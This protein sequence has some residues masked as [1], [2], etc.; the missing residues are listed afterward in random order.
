MLVDGII[1]MEKVMFVDVHAHLLDEKFTDSEALLDRA[2]FFGVEKIICASASIETSEKAFEFAKGHDGV[3]CTVGV[4]PENAE[5]YSEDVERKI[6][7]MCEN[8]KVVAVGEIGL[9]YHYDGYDKEKQKDVFL[10]QLHIAKE[11]GLP[12]QIH[13]R[14]AMEDAMKILKENKHL[15]CG[16]I[17]HCYSGSVEEAKE[18]LKL[19]TL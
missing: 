13:C 3:F 10:K 8:K 6:K 16:G 17:F 19:G 4:H 1:S 5:T 7:S 9:D 12:V 11:F 2:S 15:L 14:D 18:I